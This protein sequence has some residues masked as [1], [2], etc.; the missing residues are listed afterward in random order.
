[1]SD[2]LCLSER[3]QTSWTNGASDTRTLRCEF[4]AAMA[5]VLALQSFAYLDSGGSP[6]CVARNLI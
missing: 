1:M 6:A 5:A 2:G 3:P 4:A